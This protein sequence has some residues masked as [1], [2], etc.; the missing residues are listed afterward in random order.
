MTRL[1]LLLLGM[2]VGWNVVLPVPTVVATSP[3]LRV[4][5]NAK[6]QE[7]RRTLLV[8]EPVNYLELNQDPPGPDT[9]LEQPQPQLQQDDLVLANDEQ[10]HDLDN[11]AVLQHNDHDHEDDDTAGL[12]LHRAVEIVIMTILLVFFVLVLVWT[13]RNHSYYDPNQRRCPPMTSNNTNN[14]NTNTS[15]TATAVAEEPTSTTLASWFQWCKT[16]FA[17][18]PS[19]LAEG[20]N[21]KAHYAWQ[22]VPT[23][24]T[25]SSSSNPSTSLEQGHEGSYQRHTRATSNPAA[26]T[27]TSSHGSWYSPAMT[28]L[29]SLSNSLGST[30]L[31]STHHLQQ[32]QQQQQPSGSQS[33]YHMLYNTNHHPTNNH[34]NT[35]NMYWSMAFCQTLEHAQERI[36]HN[37]QNTFDNNHQSPPNGTYTTVYYNVAAGTQQVLYFSATQL[38]FTPLASSSS[39][40]PT[41]PRT[42]ATTHHHQNKS[43]VTA[44]STNTNATATTTTNDHNALEGW[45]ITGRGNDSD[46]PFTI[47]YGRAAA[48]GELYWIQAAPHHTSTTTPSSASHG[49]GTVVLHWALLNGDDDSLTGCSIASTASSMDERHYYS[50]V[51]LH[52]PYLQALYQARERVIQ[53][54]QQPQP[55]QQQH[56]DQGLYPESASTTTTGSTTTSTS[57]WMGPGLWSSWHPLKRMHTTT[58]TLPHTPLPQS[59]VSSSLSLSLSPQVLLFAPTNGTYQCSYYD[60]GIRYWVTLELQ[61]TLEQVVESNNPTS[62][63]TT[64]G[65]T[66]VLPAHEE[67]EDDDEDDDDD[68]EKAQGQEQGGE[69]TALV[70]AEH[71]HH[72]HP[73]VEDDGASSPTDARTASTAA[74]ATSSSDASS[75]SFTRSYWI[76]NVSGH[77]HISPSSIQPPRKFRIVEGRVSATT[78]K[79]Y[80][81]EQEDEEEPPQSSTSSST[82]L[83]APPTTSSSPEPSKNSTQQVPLPPTNEPNQTTSTSHKDALGGPEQQLDTKKKTLHRRRLH[84]PEG[85]PQSLTTGHFSF[86][87]QDFVGWRQ[88]NNDAPSVRYPEFYL[89]HEDKQH[90]GQAYQ[91]S[92]ELAKSNVQYDIQAASSSAGLYTHYYANRRYYTPMSGTYT[93]CFHDYLHPPPNHHSHHRNPMTTS[94]HE[95]LLSSTLQLHFEA[96]HDT[97]QQDQDAGDN[98]NRNGENHASGGQQDQAQQPK[99]W[100]ITGSGTN[101]ADGSEFTIVEGLVSASGKAYWVQKTTRTAAPPSPPPCP[102]PLLTQL[103]IPQPVVSQEEQD[104]FPQG[105][106]RPYRPGLELDENENEYVLSTGEFVFVLPSPSTMTHR[107]RGQPQTPPSQR[108]QE[109]IMEFRGGW[110]NIRGHKRWYEKFYFTSPSWWYGPGGRGTTGAPSS[111]MTAP[112]ATGQAFVPPTTTTATTTPMRPA[113]STLPS[114]V[115]ASS[116]T[117]GIPPPPPPPPP[118]PVPS[119]NHNNNNNNSTNGSTPHTST[120]LSQQ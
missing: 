106:R 109:P 30:L 115:V 79:T 91:M 80:W 28:Q 98:P 65:T 38:H 97:D 76:W 75:S 111:M 73:D 15:P 29:T 2:V 23:N 99:S 64:G 52:R 68:N 102:A 105:R 7:A 96:L 59:S 34:P 22:A 66:A 103:P 92:Y 11:D 89:V 112:P 43:R 69:A 1:L 119:H 37:C 110:H 55:Q 61:F 93:F 82:A 58:K 45:T 5:G 35:N 36:Q 70:A 56:A 94:R 71:H 27:T 90:P 53:E 14:S 54:E 44:P 116:P 25:S 26:T 39:T 81:V 57:T 50:H 42:G 78:G 85:P 3:P 13:F 4:Q 40:A 47:L 120:T 67:D 62:S 41:T 87:N 33:L 107:S 104:K 63:S 74:T 10:D 117:V 21:G 19:S 100:K 32:H 17:R 77:G 95:T 31:S 24:T 83:K 114:V 6:L 49:P 113:A 12:S 101:A 20:N 60:K 108:P 72:H 48:S 16:V 84:H 118:P 18:R 86:V 88:A 46:G 51:R 8:P 9:T